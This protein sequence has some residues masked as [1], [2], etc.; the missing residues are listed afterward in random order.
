MCGEKK[1]KKRYWVICVGDI[2]ILHG[3]QPQHAGWGDLT[4]SKAWSLRDQTEDGSSGCRGRAGDGSQLGRGPLHLS[5]MCPSGDGLKL[6]L[7]LMIRPPKCSKNR[8][9]ISLQSKFGRHRAWLCLEGVRN[10]DTPPAK[11]DTC[12]NPSA[13]IQAGKLPFSCAEHFQISSISRE[14]WQATHVLDFISDAIT[15]GPF[16]AT[17]GWC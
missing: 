10:T 2:F 15:F 11:R 13:G 9:I 7:V 4:E 3:W 16:Y 8:A 14:I 17:F 6:C 1:K 12:P 5:T